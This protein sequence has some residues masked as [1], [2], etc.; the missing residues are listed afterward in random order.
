[1]ARIALPVY[2]VSRFTFTAD[3]TSPLTFMNTSLGN[4]V[5]NNGAV[6]L[7]VQNTDSSSHTVVVELPNLSDE[8]QAVTSRTYTIAANDRGIVGVF[9]AKTYQTLLIDPSSALLKAAAYSLL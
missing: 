7:Y 2:A 6:L 4:V 1:M 3:S 8:T 5:N 9:P